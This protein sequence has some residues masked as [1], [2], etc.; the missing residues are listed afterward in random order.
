MFVKGLNYNLPD[1]NG[2]FG[3][4]GGAFVPEDFKA[5]LQRLDVAFE[6]AKEDEA[7]LKE[8]YDL[9]KDYS[10]RPTPLYYAK[11]LTEHYGK[12]KIYLKREEL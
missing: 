9:L 12:A 2:F 6:E 1:K 8:I 10:G 3:E 7:F 4:F 11:N 5:V